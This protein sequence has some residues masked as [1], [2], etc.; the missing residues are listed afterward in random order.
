MKI[1]FVLPGLGIAGGI[2]VVATY[3]QKLQLRG[4]DVCVVSPPAS[5]VPWRARFR[6]ILRRT[7]WSRPKKTDSAFFDIAGVPVRVLE[8]WRPVTDADLPDADVIVATFWTIAHWI[9][10]LSPGKGAR[11]Y[12][13]QG[14]DALNMVDPGPVQESYR[15]PFHKIVVSQWLSDEMRRE[16]GDEHCSV[17]PNSVDCGQFSA[18]PRGLHSTP[19]V[20]FIFSHVPCKGYD[21]ALEA[22]RRAQLQ[23]K[24]LNVLAFGTSPVPKGFV[25]PEDFNY[26]INPPQEQIGAIYSGCDVWLFPSR[27][28]GFG[29]PILE[30]MACRTP[31]VATPAGAALQLLA[32]GGGVLVPHEDPQAMADAILH[33]TRLPDDH[34][35]S[36]SDAALRTAESYSWDDAT[37]LFEQALQRAIER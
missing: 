37:G 21:L 32:H 10:G 9:N 15:L 13:V 8:T 5:P 18:P 31:V 6:S 7:G 23:E 3:A 36:M 30:A 16:Y 14:H 2:R 34:W 28:E 12:F 4:H 24:S 25:V 22:I 11:V 20:G 17:V 1:T 29:L 35:R 26:F 27:A 19:T 33:V